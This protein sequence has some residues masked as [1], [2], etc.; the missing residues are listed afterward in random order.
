MTNSD[1]LAILWLHH[2]DKLYNMA[3]ALAV[4]GAVEHELFLF[5][6]AGLCLLASYWHSCKAVKAQLEASKSG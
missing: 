2:S 1:R 6:L 5:F 3:T 4:V